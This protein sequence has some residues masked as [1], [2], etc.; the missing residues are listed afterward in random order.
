MVDARCMP[1]IKWIGLG[2]L[3]AALGG[4]TA[5]A[6]RGMPGSPNYISPQNVAFAQQI[7]EKDGYLK[8]GTY[9]TG[10]RDQPTIDALRRFQRAH[11]LR[12]SG[13]IDPDTMGLLSTH[14]RSGGPERAAAGAAGGRQIAEAPPG[15][16]DAGGA[17]AA[18]TGRGSGD[19]TLLARTM[20]QTGSPFVQ[21]MA[22]G[23]VLMVS[24]AALLLRRSRRAA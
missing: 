1:F 3:A 13:Q 11:F 15:R 6:D 21:R 9:K 24:G 7:L 17:G 20:P 12:P 19:P 8:A 4:T 23:A 22:L 14:V 5:R 16:G 18:P 10:E 2:I